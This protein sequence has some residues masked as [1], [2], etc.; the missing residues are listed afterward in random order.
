[1]FRENKNHEGEITGFKAKY[2]DQIKDSVD[3]IKIRIKKIGEKQ[4][5]LESF[6]SEVQINSI[7]H[8]FQYPVRWDKLSI[9]MVRGV[10]IFV[11]FDE[12]GFEAVLRQITVKC[13]IK[14]GMDEFTYELVLEKD[15][16][17]DIDILIAS[18]LMAKDQEGKP[19]KFL[20]KF[21]YQGFKTDS[22]DHN[23]VDN[24]L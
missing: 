5:F 17:R 12:I 23:Q 24:D 4:T 19:R 7:Q 21:I 3:E 18:Y 16:D 8:L 22:K 10:P 2:I 9:P 15:K 13:D 20:T 6:Q 1:M 11:H 14:T